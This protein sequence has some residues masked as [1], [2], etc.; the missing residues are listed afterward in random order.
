MFSFYIYTFL[1]KSIKYQ[2]AHVRC[3][4]EVGDHL[5]EVLVDLGTVKS[6]GIGDE[7]QGGSQ[8]NLSERNQ[9]VNKGATADSPSDI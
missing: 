1:I 9:D 5:I 6:T 2:R 8:S 7:N 3:L 4:P